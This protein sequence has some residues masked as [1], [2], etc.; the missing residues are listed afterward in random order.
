MRSK[1]WVAA[2]SG[3]GLLALGS[4]A[5][6]QIIA[7]SIPREAAPS[8]KGSA[9]EKKY[10]FHLFASPLAKWK[11]NAFEEANDGATILAQSATPNSNFL[12]A[13]EIAFKASRDITIGSCCRYTIAEHPAEYT[14]NPPGTL[15]AAGCFDLPQDGQHLLR[16]DLRDRRVPIIG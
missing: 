13:A 16:C 1:L 6:A 11:I 3:L 12:G 15:I 8:G 4:S 9:P 14:P 7:T 10:A 5:S 2:A